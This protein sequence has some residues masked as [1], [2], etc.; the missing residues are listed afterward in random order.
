MRKEID[1]K[2]YTALFA[3]DVPHYG[4]YDIEAGDDDAAIAAAEA[5]YKADR[6]VYDDPAWDYAGVARIVHIEDPDG[7]MIVEDK[8]LDECFIR[9]GGEADRLLCDNAANM[10]AALQEIAKTPL[11]GE[12]IE[13]EDT[14]S[15]LADAG[16]Y[17]LDDDEYNPCGDAEHDQLRDAVEAARAAIAFMEQSNGAGGRS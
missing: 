6:V 7:N 1:M 15:T 16:E 3:I 2:T 17:D 5:L 8:A 10:L 12:R 9:Y 4:S 11:W 14:R 13:D